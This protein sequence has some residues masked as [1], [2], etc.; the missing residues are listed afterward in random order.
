MTPSDDNRT[1]RAL[2]A[3]F[4]GGPAVRLWHVAP[5]ERV[6]RQ[7]ARFR[8]GVTDQPPAD[9]GSVLLIRSD[10]VVDDRALDALAGAPG[11]ALVLPDGRLVALCSWSGQ[12]LP[13]IENFAAGAFTVPPGFVARTAVELAG[14]HNQQLRKREAAY[15]ALVTTTEAPVIERQLFDASYKGVTD[16]VTKYLWPEIAF[17][18]V[19]LCARFG[20]SPNQVTLLSLVASIA[21]AWL[22]IGGWFWSGLLCAWVMALLDTIDGKLAR[23]TATSSKWGNV[24]DHGIDLVAPPIWWIAWWCGLAAG[25]P[26]SST[27]MLALVIVGHLAGKLVEQAFISTFGLKIHVWEKFDSTFRLFTARRNPNVVILTVGLLVAGPGMAFIAM[28]VW[29]W[30][31]LAVHAAR[32]L[33]AL[34]ARMRGSDIRSWLED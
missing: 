2:H 17:R 4:V 27:T 3:C 26:G 21:A 8:I 19:R 29:L 7:L 11:T 14:S 1:N 33:Q 30:L 20:I 10:A 28:M 13:L 9:A 23:V 22:F 34:V 6:R 15:A 25:M 18:C 31:S 12:A 24:F 32:Y 5:T 16:V